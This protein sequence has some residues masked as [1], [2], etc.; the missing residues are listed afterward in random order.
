MAARSTADARATARTAD[1]RI[2]CGSG[3]TRIIDDTATRTSTDATASND[4]R[5]PQIRR[6][7]DNGDGIS[8]VS[9]TT[10]A[11]DVRR[12]FRVTEQAVTVSAAC[13]EPECRARNSRV[14]A[15]PAV[16]G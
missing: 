2:A 1:V 4:R 15:C 7:T 11:T 16:Y 8:A 9:G 14:H 12:I 10:G 5:T 6:A 3:C 13:G